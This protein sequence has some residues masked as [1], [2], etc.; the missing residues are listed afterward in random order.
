MPVPPAKLKLG[1]VLLSLAP[2]LTLRGDP[3]VAAIDARS[4]NAGN[5]S[6]R[7]AAAQPP[8]PTALFRDGGGGPDAAAA[9]GEIRTPVLLLVGGKDPIICPRSTREFYDRLASEDKTL[10]VYPRMFH[11][12][13]NELG[14]EQV[15]DDLAGWLRRASHMRPDGSRPNRRR[16]DEPGLGASRQVPESWFW[17]ISIALSNPRALLTV[18]SYSEA[19]RLS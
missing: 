13:L 6:M 9:H 19:G 12:P 5:V 3:P 8:Q 16:V 14:R 10:L 11:E 17:A 15:F 4:G 2:W 7:R 18:S 1:K